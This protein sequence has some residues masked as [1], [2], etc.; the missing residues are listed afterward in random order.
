MIKLRRKET[1]PINYCALNELCPLSQ[2][3]PQ[4]KNLTKLPQL[5]ISPEINSTDFKTKIWRILP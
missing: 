4:A 1:W 3:T 5:S 2:K